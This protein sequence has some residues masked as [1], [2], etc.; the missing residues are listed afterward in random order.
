MSVTPQRPGAVRSPRPGQALFTR[1]VWRRLTILALYGYQG[2][3]A[4]FAVTALPNHLA[5]AG[6]A[7]EAIGAMLALIG[8][9]WVLQPLW[10]PLVDRFG[11][12]R[13]GRRRTWILLGL[14]GALA[15][16]AALP[17]AGDGAGALHGIGLILLLHNACASL[18]DTAVDAM[19][20]DRVPGDRLG[21][22]TAL[23][24]TGFVGG[25]ALGAA[26]F[27][28][29]A[30]THGLPFAEQLLLLLGA[31]A[32][33]IP[34]L[35]REDQ[36]DALLSLRRRGQRERGTASYLAVL[37]ELADF[38][39]RRDILALLAVCVVEEFATAA[40]GV[41]FGLDLVAT[42]RWDATSLSQ[43]QGGLTLAS[44]TVGALSIGLWLDRVGP[45]HAL[46]LLLGACV[47]AYVATALLLLLGPR[48]YALEACAM[49]L[50]SVVPALV[51]V[52]L[53]P[54]VMQ[55]IRGSGAA[56]QFALVMAAL[57][58]G[59]VL[60]SAASGHIGALLPSWLVALGGAG[61]FAL[62]TLAAAKPERLFG[63]TVQSS[64]KNE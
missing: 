33:A 6:A 59:G 50:S 49:A 19:I 3:A 45:R 39:R 29:L 58:G 57:N 62:C 63:E 43:L 47:A 38:A 55:I 16:L 42:G 61:L 9:P 10:G 46:S 11:D 24:R 18:L 8:L 2:L 21:E 5:A 60:G 34:L 17:L 41:H 32:A 35:V 51:F 15:C 25:S 56:T 13:M 27:S 22:T 64:P 23:T 31:L 4:G 37:K 28:T 48:S 7:P 40:F 54:T 44:G 20:I 52:S 36:G 26:V 30:A 53:A 14:S 12:F 1:P